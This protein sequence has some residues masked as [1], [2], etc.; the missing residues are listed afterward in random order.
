[1]WIKI[2][3]IE[4]ILRR[5][6]TIKSMLDCVIMLKRLT[7]KDVP[8]NN[9]GFLNIQTCSF[10]FF[11][12]T[13]NTQSLVVSCK[14]WVVPWY[15]LELRAIGRVSHWSS[16]PRILLIISQHWCRWGIGTCRYTWTSVYQMIKRHVASLG[17]NGCCDIEFN[18]LYPGRCGCKFQCI[19]FKLI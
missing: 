1:M 18:S 2:I 4:Y 11:W 7:V 15:P 10:N 8:I 3:C 17:F 5:I 13:P 6:L 19:I 14:Y 9:H 16:F 12:N